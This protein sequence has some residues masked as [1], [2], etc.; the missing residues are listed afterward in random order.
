MINIFYRFFSPIFFLLLVVLG[1]AIALACLIAT[2]TTVAI[3][4]AVA[5]VRGKRFG[6]HPSWNPWYKT[7]HHAA[8]VPRRTSKNTKDVIDVEARELS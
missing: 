5:K 8:Q 2:A 4:Y 6:M 3:L 7:R 1:A